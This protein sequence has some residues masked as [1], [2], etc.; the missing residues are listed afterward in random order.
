[1]TNGTIFEN[2]TILENPLPMMLNHDLF[3]FL[4]LIVTLREGKEPTGEENL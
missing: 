3:S 1:M 4:H 2:K